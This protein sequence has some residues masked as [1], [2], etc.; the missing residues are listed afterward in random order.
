M[1]ANG[2]TRAEATARILQ[3]PMSVR[4]P[5]VPHSADP[6]TE[7][8]NRTYSLAAK[9]ALGNRFIMNILVIAYY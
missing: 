7:P 3:V 6:Y 8:C 2:I 5:E 4:A 9:I 1:S